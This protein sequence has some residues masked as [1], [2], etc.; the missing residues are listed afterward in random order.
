MK[1]DDE[2]F[3]YLSS[4]H[5]KDDYNDNRPT[6]FT[7][8]ISPCHILESDYEMALENIIF[9][10]AYVYIRAG[11]PHY[12]INISVKFYDMSGIISGGTTFKYTCQ[13][14]ITGSSMSEVSQKINTDL[15][16]YLVK[17]K[18]IAENHDRI[19]HFDNDGRLLRVNHLN[20]S[21]DSNKYITSTSGLTLS[22]KF[23]ALFG[24]SNNSHQTSL[25]DKIDVGYIYCD[26]VEPSVI[27]N[28]SVHLLDILPL[29]ERMYSKTT[30]MLMFKRVSRKYIET[31][32]IKILDQNGIPPPFADDVTVTLIL[33]FKRRA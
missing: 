11:D 29:N 23:K 15:L 12:F 31:I 2:F 8:R 25:H 5:S 26:I 14:D 18:L 27:G 28:Q 13:T 19:L 6:A 33:H 21:F 1:G 4:N 17:Q 16:S 10:K 32:S 24:V 30:T 20:V 3:I 9:K 22:D 7:N